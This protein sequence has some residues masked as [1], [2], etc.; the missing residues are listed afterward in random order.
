MCF[1]FGPQSDIAPSETINDLE[2]TN[3]PQKHH[4][5]VV[6]ADQENH[7]THPRSDLIKDWTY[8]CYSIP[9]VHVLY[10]TERACVH[11][12]SRAIL[13]L[14]RWGAFDEMNRCPGLV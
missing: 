5:N 1:K 12:L 4:L 7:P 10:S 9:G 8:L 2:Y 6:I 13:L 11:Q 14:K 3:V